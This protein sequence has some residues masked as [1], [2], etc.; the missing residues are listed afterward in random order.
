MK[1]YHGSDIVIPIPKLINQT[2]RALDFGPGFYLTTS[3]E[4]AKKWAEKVMLRNKS[5]HKI[6]NEYEFPDDFAATLNAKVFEDAAND[7]WL[8]YVSACRAFKTVKEYDV[9]V[10]PVADDNVFAVLIRY[11][12][13]EL[14][15]DETLKR[16]KTTKLCNQYVAHTQKAIDLLH[17]EKAEEV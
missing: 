4:Q 12:N 3:F 2:G 8:D 11:E 10:G 13:G 9:I 7:E 14:D 16:L 5:D 15:K 6:V 17:F 1:L